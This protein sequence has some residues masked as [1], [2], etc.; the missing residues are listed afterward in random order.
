MALPWAENGKVKCDDRTG[1]KS[2]G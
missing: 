2:E 1:G